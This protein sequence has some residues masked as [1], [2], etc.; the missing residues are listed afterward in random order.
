MTLPVST[1]GGSVIVLPLLGEFGGAAVAGG[2][3]GGLADPAAALRRG[4]LRQGIRSKI[5]DRVPL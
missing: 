1:S 4:Q 5:C 2:V 3:V